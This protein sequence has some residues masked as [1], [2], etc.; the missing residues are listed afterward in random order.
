MEATCDAHEWEGACA[1]VLLPP[2]NRFGTSRRFD[3]S[4]APC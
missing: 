3:T 1:G 4:G 2:D